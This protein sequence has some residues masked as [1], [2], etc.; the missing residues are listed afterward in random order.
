MIMDMDIGIPADQR[1]EIAEGLARLPGTP[2][3][4]I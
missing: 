2:T 4:S 1:A 3:R